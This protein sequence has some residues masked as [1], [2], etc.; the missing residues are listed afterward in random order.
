MQSFLH[1]LEP[2]PK[3][4]QLRVRPCSRVDSCAQHTLADHGQCDVDGPRLSAATTRCTAAAS[5][6]WTV[7][8]ST[9]GGVLRRRGLYGHHHAAACFVAVDCT[10]ITTRQRALLPWTVPTSPRGTPPTGGRWSGAWPSTCSQGPRL[11]CS[12]CC[13]FME[14]TS[15]SQRQQLPSP[16]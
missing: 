12:H 11:P 7:P 8:T 14:A 5:S 15:C 9:R 10:D 1:S 16:H 2:H 13:V 3:P 6:P 4:A